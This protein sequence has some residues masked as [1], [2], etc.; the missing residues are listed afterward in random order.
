MNLMNWTNPVDILVV[1]IHGLD[2]DPLSFPPT[3]TTISATVATTCQSSLPSSSVRLNYLSR[4]LDLTRFTVQKVITPALVCFG[5]IGNLVNIAVLTRR[6]MKSSTNCYLTALAVYDVLYLV[7]A[8]ILSL[9]H[10]D[11]V[12]TSD[13]FI[14][15][16]SPLVRPLTDTCSNTGVWL[17]LTFTVERYIGVCHP[18]KGKVWC[19]PQS[20]KV[21]VV[22]VCLLAALVTFPEFFEFTVSASGEA[23]NETGSRLVV[24]QT[25]FGQSPG[26]SVGYRYLNQALFTFLPLLLLSIFNALLLNAVITAARW[27]Q[28]VASTDPKR[29]HRPTETTNTISCS[30]RGHQ[31]QQRITVMLITVVVVFLVCQTPQAVQHVYATYLDMS[32]KMTEEK[33]IMLRISANVFNLLVIANCCSNFI[34]YSCFSSKFRMTFHK[35]FCAPC[36]TRRKRANIEHM[37][38]EAGA[39]ALPLNPAHPAVGRRNGHLATVVCTELWPSDVTNGQTTAANRVSTRVV[40]QLASE[41]AYLGAGAAEGSEVTRSSEKNRRSTTEFCDRISP[42]TFL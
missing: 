29:D 1:G 30:S 18:M 16:K 36:L 2:E 13:L 9:S 15:F 14:R 19:T 28:G 4:Q 11:S 27:R 37:Y 6:W 25:N 38:S 24:N 34:L 21:I 39:S 17:T 41:M 42:P 33:V 31:S 7:L 8:Y 10:F 26:Y 12:R 40:K 35:L 23:M 20:A 5:V 3:P 22:I 32:S